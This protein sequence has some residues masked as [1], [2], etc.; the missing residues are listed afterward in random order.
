MIFRI[1]SM[2]SAVKRR[3]AE[4]F[5]VFGRRWR[6]LSEFAIFQSARW[7]QGNSI[8]VPAH[9]CTI[10]RLL[11]TSVLHFCLLDL[12]ENDKEDLLQQTCKTCTVQICSFFL[13]SR[14][15]QNEFGGT[16]SAYPAPHLFLSFCWEQQQYHQ[17][18]IKYRIAKNT[19]MNLEE[20]AVHI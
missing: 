14:S 18:A 17:W 5:I 2:L 3:A 9:F 11:R 10:G 1:W 6:L 7:R 12:F 15:W 20:R 4:Y 8:S 19:E 16:C 13:L